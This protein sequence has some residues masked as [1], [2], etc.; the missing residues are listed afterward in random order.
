MI[1]FLAGLVVGLLLMATFFVLVGRSKSVDELLEEHNNEEWARTHFADILIYDCPEEHAVSGELCN[2][3]GVWVCADRIAYAHEMEEPLYDVE[4]S[5]NE[6]PDDMGVWNEVEN[7][8]ECGYG[9]KIYEHQR[10]GRR[11]LWHNSTYGC[12]R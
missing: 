2:L 12:R 10:T 5:H 7:Q 11:I 6:Q 8:N 9:C 4:L 1:D 3:V